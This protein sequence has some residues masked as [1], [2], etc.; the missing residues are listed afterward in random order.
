MIIIHYYPLSK[1]K[2]SYLMRIQDSHIVQHDIGV[3]KF[4]IIKL[5]IIPSQQ[6]H[7]TMHGPHIYYVFSTR[8]LNY[9]T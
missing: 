1:K 4:S 2:L 3:H 9:I 5:Y 7:L 6:C 8:L